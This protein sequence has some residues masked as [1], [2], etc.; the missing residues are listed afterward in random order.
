MAVTV[1]TTTRGYQHC[2]SRGKIKWIF[3]AVFLVV[4]GGHHEQLSSLD[5]DFQSKILYREK[6]FQLSVLAFNSP[7]LLFLQSSFFWAVLCAYLSIGQRCL[8]IQNEGSRIS[9]KVPMG[10]LNVSSSCQDTFRNLIDGTRSV[11]Y[12]GNFAKFQRLFVISSFSSPPYFANHNSYYGPL[13]VLYKLFSLFL[14]AFPD[15]S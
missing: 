15:L 10:C 12:S 4:F 3:A 9:D 2:L 14:Q 7:A 6:I 5:A 1:R 8:C 13:Q 11:F